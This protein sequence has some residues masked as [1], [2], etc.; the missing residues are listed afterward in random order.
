MHIVSKASDNVIAFRSNNQRY[1]V[2]KKGYEWL[3]LEKAHSRVIS[4][5]NDQQVAIAQVR[6]LNAQAFS[7]DRNNKGTK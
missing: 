2:V 4:S 5:W 1:T 6:T 7:N 3:V